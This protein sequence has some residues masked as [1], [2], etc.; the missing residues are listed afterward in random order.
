MDLED[1]PFSFPVLLVVPKIGF[2]ELPKG[3]L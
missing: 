3:Q 2:S 1:V